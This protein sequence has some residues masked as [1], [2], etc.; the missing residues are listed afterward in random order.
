MSYGVSRWL[1]ARPSDVPPGAYRGVILAA[2]VPAA[3]LPLEVVVAD[4]PDGLYRLVRSYPSRPG[5]AI[6]PALC[7][8][9]WRAFG[10]SDDDA[11]QPGRRR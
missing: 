2:G 8:A 5:K 7:L 3:L 6:R 10:G 4:G 11:R 9:T 1:R